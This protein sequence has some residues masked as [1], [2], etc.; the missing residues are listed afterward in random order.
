MEEATELEVL[1]AGLAGKVVCCCIGGTVAGLTCGR[2]E[3]RVTG[4][5]A[6]GVL[7]LLR[8][9]SAAVGVAGVVACGAEVV[10]GFMAEVVADEV[11]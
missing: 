9:W 3:A 4:S 6:M 1:T 10:T 2:L 7:V 5:T 8:K 11:V